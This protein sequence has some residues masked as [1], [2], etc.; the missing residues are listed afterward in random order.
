MVFIWILV[1]F[2]IFS[3]I[4]LLHEYGHYKT[5]KFF[6]IHVEEFWLWIPPRAKKLW[7]NKDGT[8]FS[9]NWIPL[10]WFVK[11]SGESEVFLE[12]YNK[13][14]KLL[15]RK[16]L[17]EKVK[18]Y[19]D[20]YDKNGRKISKAEE[21]YLKSYLKHDEKGK[22]FYEKNIFQK[23]LVLLAWVIMNFVLAVFIFSLLF[24]IGTKPLGIN[25]FIPTDHPSKIIPTLDRAIEE[26][27]I[28]QWEW[29]VFFP[30]KD[31]IAEKAWIQ[32]SDIIL[33][34]NG[35][36]HKKIEDIQS[37][38]SEQKDKEIHLYIKR[39]ICSSTHT[40]S[41]SFYDIYLQVSA[42]WKI[43]T[44]LSP[45]YQ[46]N[47]DFTHKYPLHIAVKYALLETYYQIDLTLWWLKILVSNMIFPES[48]EDRQEAINQV[49][50]PIWIV[51]VI[52]DSLQ[53]WVSLLLILSAIISINLGVFNLLPIPALDG[54][55]L[56][57][58]WM[59]ATIEKIIWKSKLANHIENMTHVIFFLL[60]IA[61][62]VLIAYND[63]V[64]IFSE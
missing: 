29:T 20:I 24:F 6:W 14:K 55:R 3:V 2:L 47:E 12:Y 36:K 25:T 49:A 18:H 32:N 5:A 27:L 23:S 30:I 61:L 44:Y 39:K 62:S 11:I 17:L 1:S 46:V 33:S 48:P 43:G 52:T 38:I 40:C 26:W 21:K 19:D 57:L 35:M 58:L 56:L 22:N 7:K 51:S 64:K 16:K 54:G 41:N 13:H 37:Y 63:I 8:L 34:I 28:I 59:R 42:E 45:N 15:S 10:G 53:G 4:V 31:S 50:G 9:L 60:L